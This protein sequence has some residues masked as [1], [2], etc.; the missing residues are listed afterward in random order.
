[1]RRIAF[2]VCL[3]FLCWADF[4]FEQITRGTNAPVTTYFK[5]QRLARVDADTTVVLDLNQRTYTYIDHRAKTYWQFTA[6]GFEALL[7]GEAPKTEV[8]FDAKAPGESKQIDGVAADRFLLQFRAPDLD[9]QIDVWI[10]DKVAGAEEYRALYE[11]YKDKGSWLALARL[12]QPDFSGEVSFAAAKRLADELLRIEGVPL[13]ITTRTYKPTPPIET[14]SKKGKPKDEYVY[15]DPAE[16]PE[17]RSKSTRLGERI[18]GGLGGQ[19]GATLGSVIG[20]KLSKKKPK[21]NGKPIAGAEKEEEPEIPVSEFP[22]SS[23][24][25]TET[26]NFSTAPIDEAVFAI[27]AGYQAT[28]EALSIRHKPSF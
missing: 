1:M 17:Q 12:R 18:G 4:R 15:I 5:F 11:L 6:S 16:D 21:K 8:K 2:A 9:I 3:P 20:E 13:L 28:K 10:A 7:A 24:I 23:E 26:R 19:A 22:L 27:P 25:V 14:A